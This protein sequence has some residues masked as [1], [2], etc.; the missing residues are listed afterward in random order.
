MAA[1]AVFALVLFYSLV[2]GL[3]R[4]FYK[5]VVQTLALV[6]AIYAA[7]QGYEV[8]GETLANQSGL[9]LLAAEAAA[10]VSIW[11][12]VFFVTAVVGRL[13]LKKLRGKGIDDN[14]GEG[15][16]AVADAIGGDTTK[17][18]MTLL[19]DPIASK[20]G[21]FYWSDKILGAGLGLLKGAVS[22]YVLF[23]VVLYADRARAWESSFARSIEASHAAKLF[24][25][26]IEGTFLNSIPAY[27]IAKS[28]DDMKGIADLVDDKERGPERLERLAKDPRLKTIREHPQVKALAQDPEIMAAWDAQRLS[29]L[30]KNPKIRDLLRDRDL[31]RRVSNVEWEDIR[32]ELKKTPQELAAEKAARAGGAGPGPSP[33]PTSAQDK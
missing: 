17:G 3:R 6:V 1:D 28:V 32:T 13:L 33:S 30:L 5:E 18:P 11:V 9:P 15:A 16:E 8:G 14:L 29:E 24:T 4:G 22:A 27:R 23:G 20:R 31:R 25:D 21:I 19:T 10:A 26:H 2:F 7:Y 12:G